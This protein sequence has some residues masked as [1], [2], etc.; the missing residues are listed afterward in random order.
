MGSHARSLIALAAL[1]LLGLVALPT[2][3][4]RVRPLADAPVL[5]WL[6]A[7]LVIALCLLGIA[8][9]VARAFDRW[10]HNTDVARL[11]V[12]VLYLALIQAIVRQPL[13]L[14]LGAS[15]E[16][17]IIEAFLGGSALVLLLV[18]LLWLHSAAY[19][20]LR[21]LV[22][23]GLDEVVATTGSEAT[24]A[25]VAAFEAQQDR[26]V[27][28][29]RAAAPA[30]EPTLRAPALDLDATRP[31]ARAPRPNTSDATVAA[32]ATRPL[33]PDATQRSVR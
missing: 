16:P 1:A 15:A 28:A 17:F 4:G 14:V 32:D 2:T 30:A 5:L 9:S 26:T 19:P 6:G 20:M 12:V 29:P 18:G 22:L 21:R 7:A 23:N 10:L 25:A 3:L 8:P 27:A 11:L 13:V 31:G 33:D 24:T